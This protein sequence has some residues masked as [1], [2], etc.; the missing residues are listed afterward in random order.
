MT[1][2]RAG[3]GTTPLQYM[4]MYTEFGVGVGMDRTNGTARYFN[5][6]TW[7]DGTPT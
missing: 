1:D 6:A 7:A 2:P 4:M 5:S 3:N